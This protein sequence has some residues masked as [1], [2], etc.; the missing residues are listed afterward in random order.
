MQAKIWN[1]SAWIAETAPAKIK[2]QFNAILKEC[3][4]KVLELAE[5]HF[6][7]QGY[8]ALW[9]LAESH[10]AVHT[11]PEYGKA[12]I[13]LSSCSIEYYAKFIE[14]TKDL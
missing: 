2:A 4:F 1:H 12:Y 10:F 6:N 14:L 3:G 9:L 8:T 11:F 13:E 7:P 5:H